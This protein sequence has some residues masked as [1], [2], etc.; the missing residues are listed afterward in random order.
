MRAGSVSQAVETP[1][2]ALENGNHS[3][4]ICEPPGPRVDSHVAPPYK[5][6]LSS[7]MAIVQ[8]WA[9]RCARRVDVTG[10]AELLCSLG[11][12]EEADRLLKHALLRHAQVLC[13]AG[14]IQYAKSFL[15]GILHALEGSRDAPPRRNIDLV[16]ATKKCMDRELL[17]LIRV[18]RCEG[19]DQQLIPLCEKLRHYPEAA[20]ERLKI[21]ILTGGPRPEFVPA[22]SPAGIALAYLDRA[23]GS[24]TTAQAEADSEYL[25]KRDKVMFYALIGQPGSALQCLHEFV[26]ERSRKDLDQLDACFILELARDP[27]IARFMEPQHADQKEW[28]AFFKSIDLPLEDLKIKFDLPRFMEDFDAQWG[29]PD[30]GTQSSERRCSIS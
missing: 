29:P 6:P 20:I 15:T 16:D 2:P 9:N 8:D 18:R 12:Y 5:R 1:S 11:R 27:A 19:H 14:E 13:E 26:A 22:S 25:P 10:A 3:F 23:N 28:N 17:A 21:H 7:Q 30:V 4:S 24:R